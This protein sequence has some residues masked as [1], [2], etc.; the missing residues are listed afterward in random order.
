VS[1]EPP[2]GP[3]PV[4]PQTRIAGQE[5]APA[6]AVPHTPGLPGAVAGPGHLNSLAVVS[7]VASIASFF[8]HIIPFIG[9]TVVAI[10]AIATGFMARNEIKRTGEDGMWMAN[11]GIIIG[12]IHLIGLFILV[13]V[14]VFLI[15]VAGIAIFGIATHGGSPS[16]TPVVSGA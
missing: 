13:I 4:E 6:T 3:P 7:F 9:G 10:V 16:P 12:F 5:S 14:L 2:A 11:L 8:A 15:F 1:Q